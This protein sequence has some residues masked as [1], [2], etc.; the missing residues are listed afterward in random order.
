MISLHLYVELF[1]ITD[2]LTHAPDVLIVETAQYGEYYQGR[3]GRARIEPQ[4]LASL[5][6][7]PGELVTLHDLLFILKSFNKMKWCY[8]RPPLCTLFRL[9]W[10]KQAQEIMI[11]NEVK[12]MTKYALC[13]AP[14]F[15]GGP[16]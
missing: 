6:R 9:H 4:H 5:T 16:I 8:F 11:D 2:R 7:R 1:L 10:G 3:G 14:P 12:L 13:I 15:R